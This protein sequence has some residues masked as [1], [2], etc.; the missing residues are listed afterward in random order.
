MA[1][2]PAS[3]LSQAD[4]ESKITLI[5]QCRSWF[6]SY[7]NNMVCG[8]FEYH[9]L[10][11]LEGQ[12]LLGE[13]DVAAWSCITVFSDIDI[14]VHP[15]ICFSH[16]AETRGMPGW[17]VHLFKLSP[18]LPWGPPTSGQTPESVAAALKGENM[19]KYGSQSLRGG[20]IGRL[21]W[22]C[23]RQKQRGRCEVQ[24]WRLA[25]WE[26]GEQE[27]FIRVLTVKLFSFSWVSPLK[28]SWGSWHPCSKR[29]HQTCAQY[30]PFRFSCSFFNVHVQNMYYVPHLVVIGSVRAQWCFES[31]SKYITHWV[32]ST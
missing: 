13:G 17:L 2:S 8:V 16:L 4:P 6:S 31:W 29:S 12:P 18:R 10:L 22:W 26:S 3:A 23:R 9:L 27:G 30:L 21:Q 5:S 11:L 20:K 19:T 15:Y 7:M 24:H 1:T 14:N 28:P 25:R 32:S